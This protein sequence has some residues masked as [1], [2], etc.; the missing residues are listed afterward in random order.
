MES[1]LSSTSRKRRGS[2]TARKRNAGTTRM[3]T[4]TKMPRLPSPTRPRR[5]TSLFCVSEHSSNEPSAVTSPNPATC[6]ARP[7]N[8]RPV[9]C[10]DVE[11][12]P[13]TV[14][15]VMSPMFA[16]ATPAAARCWLASCST[17][18]AGIRAIIRAVSMP[19]PSPKSCG[20]SSTSLLGTIGVKLC[21]LPAMRIR[22]PGWVLRT[23]CCSS[24]TVR[25]VA[26]VE[27]FARTLP[28]Q[29]RHDAI[30]S[31]PR[32]RRFSRGCCGRRRRRAPTVQS[33]RA[34]RSCSRGRTPASRTWHRIPRC[35]RNTANP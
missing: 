22:R 15:A 23:R 20:F 34:V 6:P 27:G 8:V 26:R 11:I 4:H 24:S 3:S 1:K 25:G 16:S 28:A 14:W 19:T 18:P 2:S 35:S 31:P 9:P 32:V 7:V 17:I 29:F 12:E 30:T 33:A 13:A 21:P 10:V 5:Q